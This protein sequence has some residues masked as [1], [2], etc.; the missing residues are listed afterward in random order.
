MLS[1]AAR[2]EDILDRETSA[3]PAFATFVNRYLRLL[4]FPSDVIEALAKAEIN[5]FEAEQ[6]A[7]VSACRMGATPGQSK[8]TRNELLTSH[9]QTKSSGAGLWRRGNELL[10][11]SAVEGYSATP[12]GGPIP[13][14]ANTFPMSHYL[15]RRCEHRLTPFSVPCG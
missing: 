1:V 13:C 12:L 2:L 9:L 11:G 8:R 14:L 7:R 15:S 5:S 10:S 6:L 4:D 3:H